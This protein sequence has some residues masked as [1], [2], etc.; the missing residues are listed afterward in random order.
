PALEL[1]VAAGDGAVAAVDDAAQ[2]AFEAGRGDASVGGS[3]RTWRWLAMAFALLW[4]GTLA[5][6]L[7]ARR[8]ARGARA[9]GRP[10]VT[11][12][13]M[14]VGVSATSP[15]ELQ[16]L[17][18]TADLGEVELAL[19]GLAS[20]PASSLDALSRRL[21]AAAQREALALLQDARW[22][23]GDPA[24]ARQALREAFVAGPRW[25]SVA[26]PDASERL[27]PPLYPGPRDAH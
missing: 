10:D 1:D 15:R 3:A 11:G 20:P 2:A 22:N 24:R 23:D 12:E 17:L 9:P 18:Q 4:L 21:D 26:S 6:L 5:W 25:R 13:D 7:H 19:L 14:P 27:L 8:M 16:R